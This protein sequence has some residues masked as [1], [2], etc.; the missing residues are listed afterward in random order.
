M[1]IGNQTAVPKI[2]IVV[3]YAFDDVG[4]RSHLESRK[5]ERVVVGERVRVLM[6]G[7]Y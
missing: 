2:V 4:K 5:E 6:M 7:E 1:D 3:C